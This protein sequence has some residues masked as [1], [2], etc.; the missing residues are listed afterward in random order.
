MKN[1]VSKYGKWA[2]IVGGS[3]GIGL[4][5]AD[6]LAQAGHNLVLVARG[7]GDLEKS[8]TTLTARHN[9][10]V[11]TLAL[12]LTAP[13]GT[14]QLYEQTK[15]LNPGLVV[16]SAAMET[17]AHFT[18]VTANAHENLINLN[19]QVPAI[20]ARLY[21]ADMIERERGGIVFFSS[22]FGYQ[23]VP[24]VA[25]YAASKAYILT[26]GEALHVEM[27]PQGVDVLVIS[28][29]LTDTDMPAKMPINFRKM[30]IIKQQPETVARIGL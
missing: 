28:P 26:L 14:T 25:N 13:N 16:L 17:T 3:A 23:G 5:F 2:I 18:K 4:A 7:K 19:V 20:L 11:K 1:T 8:A 24:L 30:P 22:V 6:Q 10:E 15:A 9:V 12:D 27:K 29:G 21:G